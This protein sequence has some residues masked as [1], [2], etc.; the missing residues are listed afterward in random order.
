MEKEKGS[1]TLK[2]LLLFAGGAIGIGGAT[3]LLHQIINK[4][5]LSPEAAEGLNRILKFPEEDVRKSLIS[6]VDGIPQKGVKVKTLAILSRMDDETL[7]VLADD[8][9]A[10]KQLLITISPSP[11]DYLKKAGE[12]MAKSLRKADEAQKKA[13][14]WLEKLEKR[15][16]RR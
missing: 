12:S 16:R 2:D 8:A 14:S 11:G 4:K 6:F 1:S 3:Y 15:T 7:R 9:S 10:Q 5:D 13:V